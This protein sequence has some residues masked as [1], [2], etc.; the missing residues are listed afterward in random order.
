MKKVH[1]AALPKIKTIEVS[2]GVRYWEDA[3]VNG[4]DDTEGDKIPMRNVDNWAPIIDVSTGVIQNWPTGTHASIHYN[5]CDQ[6]SAVFK[7]EK[8][9]T[10]VE[11]EDEY[12]PDFMAPGG[13]GYGDYIILEIDSY[14]RIKDWKFSDDMVTKH[15][16]DEDDE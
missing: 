13:D 1:R 16:D 5:V 2:A 3:E 8:G 9:E 10:V 11:I 6:F 14:G 7:D 4:A 15:G 12:V